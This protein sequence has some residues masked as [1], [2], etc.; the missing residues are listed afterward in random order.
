MKD[1]TPSANAC[2]VGPVLEQ[3]RDHGDVLQRRGMADRSRAAEERFLPLRRVQEKHTQCF[4]TRA[5]DRVVNGR[6]LENVDCGI[7]CLR[8]QRLAH[9]ILLEAPEIA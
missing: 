9:E 7:D 3:H 2:R 8:Q 4:D 1:P 5:G 6:D